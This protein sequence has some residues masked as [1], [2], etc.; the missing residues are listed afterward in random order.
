MPARPYRPK[1]KAKGRERRLNRRKR[2]VM[3]K[4][5]H[6]TFLARY[7]LNAAIKPLLAAPQ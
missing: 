5:R 1:D 6:Q 2:W 3:A 4:L 7:E